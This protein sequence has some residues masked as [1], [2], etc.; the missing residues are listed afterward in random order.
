MLCGLL[1]RPKIDIDGLHLTMEAHYESFVVRV[2]VNPGGNVEHGIVVHTETGAKNSFLDVAEIAEIV[3]NALHWSAENLPN[4][5]EFG[6][7]KN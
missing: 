7:R 5:E 2:W 1:Q 6:I 4:G 3:S